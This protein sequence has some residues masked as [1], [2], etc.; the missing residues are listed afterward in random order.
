MANR[1]HSVGTEPPA[2]IAL[3]T[4]DGSAVGVA[5]DVM[6]QAERVSLQF[7]MSYDTSWTIRDQLIRTARSLLQRQQKEYFCALKELSLTVRRGEVVGIIGPNGSGKTTLL[8]VISGILLPDTGTVTTRGRISIL[9]SLGA[10]FNQEMTGLNNI[11][12]NALL[13]GLLLEDIET[14]IDEVASFTELGEFLHVPMKFYS[15][16]MVSR[17]NFATLLLVEPEIV[18]IDEI[19][20]VGDLAFVDKSGAAMEAMLEKAQCQILATH[21]LPLVHER[22][23]RAILIEHG[24]IIADGDPVDVVSEYHDRVKKIRDAPI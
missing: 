10:G 18:L 22:C 7:E 8:R 16:G 23:T 20:S 6:I 9:L 4:D 13:S 24:R 19:F 12:M 15:S 1:L 14:R 5:G 2:K 11:R 17:L 3:H 21:A